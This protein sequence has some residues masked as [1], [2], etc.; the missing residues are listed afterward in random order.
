MFMADENENGTVGLQVPR[1]DLE[2][3]RQL[4]LLPAPVVKDNQDILTGDG[5]AAVVIMRN[6]PLL[7][8]EKNAPPLSVPTGTGA[9]RR[10]LGKLDIY[11][12]AARVERQRVRDIE[13]SL[14]RKPTVVK[15]S[16]A[17]VQQAA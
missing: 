10:V 8:H 16:Q 13:H 3:G 14:A 5:K 6:D 15:F 12:K 7:V 4:A 9:F 1:A 2:L 11:H 17:E